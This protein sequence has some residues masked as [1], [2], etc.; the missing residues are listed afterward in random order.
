[1]ATRLILLSAC[2]SAA[3]AGVEPRAVL[4]PVFSPAHSHW[5]RADKVPADQ[6]IHID[7]A[8]SLDE[9]T[10]EAATKALQ[11]ISDPNS[12]KYGQHLS[13][14]DAADLFAPPGENLR[15]VARWLNS[16]G[17][18][19]SRLKV[20][21]DRAHISFDAPVE[22]AERLLGAKFHLFSFG[23][24]VQIASEDY[25]VPASIS[26]YIDFV[27]P[28]T[29][30]AALLAQ[31][32]PDSN[33]VHFEGGSIQARQATSNDCFKYMSPHCLRKLYNIDDGSGVTP[34]PSNSYGFF[35]PS[36]STWLPDDMESFF[37]TLAPELS[38]QQPAV[39]SINGG[40]RFFD[41]ELLPFNLEPNLDYQYSM[42]MAYP[43]PV[44]NIQ[45]GDQYQ[46]G[47]INS[48]LAAFDETYCTALDPE[49]DPIFPSTEPGG[50]NSTS[51][52]GTH[53]PP[54]VIGIAYGW[55]EAEFSDTYVKRQCLEFLKLGLQGITVVTGS[56]DRGTADQLGGCIDPDTGNHNATE[57]HFSSVFPASCPW[58]TVVGGT[59]LQSTASN[60]SWSEGTPFPPEEVLNYNG[61]Q[62]GG[63][64]SRLF[65]AP[66]YQGHE[67]KGYL[68][69]SN[70][71]SQ[72]GEQGYFN[73]KGRGYPDVSA[74]GLNYLVAIQGGFRTVRGTSASIPLVASMF[75]KINQARLQTGKTTIGFVN[76]VLYGFR[77]KYVRDVKKGANG[78]CGI[79]V[80]FEAADGWDAVTGLG[81]P[82]Y[83]K[84]LKVYMSLP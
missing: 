38:G 84:L 17:I 30:P 13:P 56:A 37:S 15:E 21:L 40:Y 6:V 20:S 23:A 66:W 9:Q 81:S 58:I 34:H 48:M 82:D 28:A 63:G 26:N 55:N 50:Y 72:L 70:T 47:N 54:K 19:R 51:D 73:S 12:A 25:S 18:D 71:A 57:G 61:T 1:M 64:F 59:Q 78:G 60:E 68:A 8:L 24:E 43:Q 32:T 46:I 79:D 45:V 29:Q 7:V 39:M 5:K 75:A 10:S 33:E 49:F 4:D 41:L 44:T 35:T 80:A 74:L 11:D 76:P 67:T 69:Q 27:M 22:E 65:Q 62:S 3:L 42:S 14:R 36:Y 83:E 77:N 2:F 16:S 31:F 52:C 53:T